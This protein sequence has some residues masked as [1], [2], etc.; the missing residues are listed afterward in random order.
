MCE[1]DVIMTVIIIFV[2]LWISITIIPLDVIIVVTFVPTV[3]KLV[4]EI[5]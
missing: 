5:R 4:H 3:H 1:V 2:S